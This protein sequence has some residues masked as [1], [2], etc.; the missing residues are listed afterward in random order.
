MLIRN[1]SYQAAVTSAF[2][3]TKFGHES[4]RIQLQHSNSRECRE[5]AANTTRP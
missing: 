3:G 5:P 4:G 1:S 2:S